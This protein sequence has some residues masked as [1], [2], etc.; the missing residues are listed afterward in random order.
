MK[1]L[2]ISIIGGY[3]GMGSLFASVFKEAGHKVVISGPNTD[4][5][6]TKAQ[7]L[8]VDFIQDNKKAVSGSDV[9]IITVPME[10]TSTVISEI[11]PQV[12]PGGL[13]MDFTSVKQEP[14][15]LMAEKSKKEVEVVGCHPVFGPRVRSIAGQA[16]ILCPIR[17]KKWFSWLMDLLEERKARVFTAT[18]ED[19]DH[20]MAVIQGLTHYSYLA[21]GKTLAKLDFNVKESRNYSSPVYDMM[22]D[23]VGR[24]LGQNPRLYAEIQIENPEVTGM[25]QLFLESAEEL[26]SIVEKGDRES[27]AK[28][29]RSAAKNFGE[30]EEALGRSDKAINSLMAELELLKN[31]LG[32][33]ICL[34]HIYSGIRHFGVLVD[35][36]PGEVVLE[37]QGKKTT[38]KLSNLRILRGEEE[39][40]FLKEKFGVVKRD[41]SFIYPEGVDEA[42]LTEIIGRDEG[43]LSCEIK[44]VYTGKQVGEGSK[45]VCF[46]VEFL[47]SNINEKDEEIKSYFKKFGGK[48]R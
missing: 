28:Y 34:Q 9:V 42:F 16:F 48:P 40:E 26:K 17:G 45:S 38:L 35:L 33:D 24:I 43:V 27:F 23:M 30:V 31:S 41:Y 22:L 36:T 1:V 39:T 11:A 47:N 29:M 32:K 12:K 46:T 18:P 5:G 7:D 14:C 8:G 37:D 4:K 6:R 44:D 10:T 21:F 2:Q 15:R 20:T 25:H 3:G 19:H 13:L